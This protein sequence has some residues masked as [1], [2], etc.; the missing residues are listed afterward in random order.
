VQFPVSF[1]RIKKFSAIL[2]HVSAGNTFYQFPN[3]IAFL[4]IQILIRIGLE[5]SSFSTIEF[6]HMAVCNGATVSM[7]MVQMVLN[8]YQTFHQN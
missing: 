2:F 7:E 8:H 4:I 5:S 1:D 6:V 3:T